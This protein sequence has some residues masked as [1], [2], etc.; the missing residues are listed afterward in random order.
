MGGELLGELI[1]DV[2]SSP[3]WFE[4]VDVRGLGDDS[5]RAILERVKEKLGFNKDL[6]G[7]RYF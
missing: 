6:R 4:R 2:P 7:L 1:G 5:R 3:R